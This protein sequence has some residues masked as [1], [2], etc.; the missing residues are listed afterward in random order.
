MTE[1]V[2]VMLAGAAL[3]TIGAVA[4]CLWAWRGRRID[5]HPL[6]R[7]CG[8]DLTGRPETSR[9]CP[10]CGRDVTLPR[11][12]RVGHRRKRAGWLWASGGALF[13]IAVVAG[14]GGYVV[15]RKVD[16]V[17]YE[18]SWWLAR[19][20]TS[21]DVPTRAAALRELKVR[22]GDKRA[23]TA[24]LLPAIDRILAYQADL[25]HV[26]D[27][28]WGDLVYDAHV[29]GGLDDARWRRYLTQ[30]M[31]LTG[32]CRS[33]MPPGHSV[34]VECELA[35]RGGNYNASPTLYNVFD[36]TAQVGPDRPSWSL[37]G[38]TGGQ[39]YVQ[40]LSGGWTY[41][42][43]AMP[44]VGDVKAVDVRAKA[45]V[46]LWESPPRPSASANSQAPSG[47][48]PRPKEPPLV[49]VTRTFVLPVIVGDDG[50]ATTDEAADQ[51]ARIFSVASVSVAPNQGFPSGGDVLG[52]DLNVT[53]AP[54][55]LAYKA[56]LFI[57]GIE[58]SPAWGDAGLFFAPAQR[59][60]RPDVRFV[61]P[62][63][64]A[65]KAQLVLE[66]SADAARRSIDIYKYSSARVTLDVALPAP[67]GPTTRMTSRP[68]G[69]RFGR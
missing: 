43:S 50:C 2:G 57:D 32:K 54:V 20:C 4:A 51:V 52:I 1:L 63:N 49:E 38:A 58:A 41:F 44:E 68:S 62:H 13:L 45:T 9:L 29:A 42:I 18:P 12:I 40:P 47:W 35:Y 39:Q 3:V 59:W 25:S 7:K 33:K 16:L 10:E 30:M 26:W 46:C 55:N 24:T 8:F 17:P 56:R 15:Y 67:S 31:V 6:C 11:A 36:C 48:I 14:L 28:G 69:L 65:G 61:V 53:S 23:G 22:L 64:V 66:P 21:A 27:V 37:G 19:Q 5:D 34:P 60:N